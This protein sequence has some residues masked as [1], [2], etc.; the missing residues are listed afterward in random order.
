FE[1]C[2]AAGWLRAQ[3]KI[4]RANSGPGGEEHASFDRMIQ[5]AHVSGPRMLVEGF[6][7]RRIKGSDVLAVAL[8][9]ALKEV[10]GK[11]IDVF[12]PFAKRRQVNL[13]G[14]QPEEKV[15]TKA[16][17]SGLCVDVGERREDIDLLAHHRSEEHTSEL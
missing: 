14:I 9:V 15:L 6:E 3:A 2:G 16:A 12:A 1:L 17:G 5:F 4:G 11:E 8:R 10:V 13:D 7:G